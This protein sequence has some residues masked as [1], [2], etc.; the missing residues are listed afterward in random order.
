MSEANCILEFK[1]VCFSKRRM[2]SYRPC[3]ILNGE[4]ECAF[5][6]QITYT[7]EEKC[8]PQE[9]TKGSFYD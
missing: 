5:K 9:Y 3:M 4:K 2:P 8:Q 6:S 7:E 1:G